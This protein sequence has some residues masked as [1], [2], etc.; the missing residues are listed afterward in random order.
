MAESSDPQTDGLVDN[1]AFLDEIQTCFAEFSESFKIDVEGVKASAD[2]EAALSVEAALKLKTFLFDQL[3]RTDAYLEARKTQVCV[4]LR[5][6]DVRV[7]IWMFSEI[8]TISF[9]GNT[10]IEVPPQHAG[11]KYA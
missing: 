2:T 5:S 8:E 9:L 6:C 10:T 11:H 4:D 7:V 3:D 1:V